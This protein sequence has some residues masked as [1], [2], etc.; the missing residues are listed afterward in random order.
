[1]IVLG[2]E[3]TAHTFGVGIAQDSE[4]FILVNEKSTF[5]PKQG[6]M[7]PSE[8]ASHHSLVAAEVISKALR[9]SKKSM[10]DID[11][12]AVSLGPGIGPALRVGAA[13]ARALSLKYNK[14]LVP[15]NHGIAHIEIGYLTT[16]A[17]DPLILYLSGGNTI[18]TM[19]YKGK[20]RIFGETLDMALGNMLDTFVRE[21]GLAPPYIING[22]HVIDICADKG[23][24]LI[25]L[26]YIVKGQDM[27]YAGLLTAALRLKGRY[28]VEDLCYTVREIAFDMLIEA[29]ERALALTNKKE[30]LV[31]GGVA[32]SISLKRKLEILS[33]EW[34]IELKIVPNEF[35]TDNGAMIAY[36]GVL[37]A[38]K[39]IFI[40]IERSYI[41]PRWRIDEVEILWR[42]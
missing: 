37:A 1:M 29:T 3:S 35:A 9:I 26:P 41:R 2:I 39:G 8:L 24:K 7:K 18:I 13:V 38:S 33:E 12:I 31:V 10:K 5:V 36:T 27:S 15:I 4:P 40:D 30:L 32:A 11:Y 22:I 19:F 28:Q 14:K 20:F 21:M 16:S 6:G 25:N 17:K 23:K 34:G 42:S